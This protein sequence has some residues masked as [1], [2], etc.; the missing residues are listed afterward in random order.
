[1]RRGRNPRQA[2][3]EEGRE[4][5]PPTVGA[6][7]A[8]GETTVSPHCHDCHHSAIVAT[9]RFPADLPIPDIALRLRCSVCGSERIGVM[10]DMEAHYAR[11]EAKTGWMMEVKPC[12]RSSRRGDH[13]KPGCAVT[14]SKQM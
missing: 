8:E 11:I 13:H 2:Y 10:K 7:R 12:R 6:G 5:A 3:N 9:D 4:I 14:E 1:M